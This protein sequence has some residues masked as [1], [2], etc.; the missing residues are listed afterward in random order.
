M[1]NALIQRIRALSAPLDPLPTGLT[2]TVAPMPG[3]RAAIFDVYGTLIVSGV[4]DISLSQEHARD[5]GIREAL[6]ACGFTVRNE[7]A[8]AAFGRQLLNLIH[9][10]QQIQ[11]D[12]G[13]EFP[14]VDI[15]AVWKDLLMDWR[16]AEI[17]EGEAVEAEILA[18]EYEARVNPAWP[19]PRLKETLDELRERGVILGIVSNAQF[20]TPLLFEAFL[21]QS[22][23]KLGFDLDLC[24]WSYEHL[25][26][27]PSTQLY[28]LAAQRLHEKYSI[29]PQ[30]AVFVG[31]DRRNDVWPAQQV[32]FQT[33][34]YAGDQRSLRLREDDPN[35]SRVQA[36]A[37]LTSVDQILSLFPAV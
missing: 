10:H 25:Q 14:E 7:W 35:C 37:V 22:L 28:E 15:R 36:D 6:H 11:R 29:S 19:M 18:I 30:Q 33:A 9:S 24:I 4:G 8:D 16:R 27:K 1:N 31:N 23:D 3:L 5:E 32:G 2:A 34:L 17:I 20:F 12:T 13:T 26:G 21:E